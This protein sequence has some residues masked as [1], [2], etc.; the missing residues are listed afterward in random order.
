MKFEI[1][2]HI[3]VQFE[4]IEDDTDF[5]DDARFKKVKVWVA[6]E[7]KNLNNSNFSLDVLNKMGSKVAG[8]PI[9]GYVQKDKYGDIDFKG[10][11]TRLVIEGDD[12]KFDYV[13]VPFGCI[14]ETNNAQIEPKTV[15]GVEKNF[16]T[17]EGVLWNKF[18]DCI[19]IFERDGD[20]K[21]Q[22]MELLPDSIKGDFKSDGIYYFTEAVIDSLCILGENVN[23]AMKGGSLDT[24]FSVS[25]FK[26]QYGE[27]IKE[28]KE[29]FSINQSLESVDNTSKETGGDNMTKTKPVEPIVEP[30]VEPTVPVT[31]V[32]EAP[33]EPA[34]SDD[35]T[36][37]VEPVVP[38]VTFS[39]TGEQFKKELKSQ[40]CEVKVKTDWDYV[41]A[42]YC[43]VD[44]KEDKVFAMDCLE[45]Y[46][47]YSFNFT[48][49]GDAVV[50]D[51]ASKA[52]VKVEYLPFEGDD[53][54]TGIED[55][56]AMVMEV[57]EVF[58]K[59]TNDKATEDA[60]KESDEKEKESEAK[61]ATL[62]AEA[63]TL[64]EFQIGVQADERATQ[65]KGIFEKYSMLEGEVEFEAIKVDATKF[66]VIEL[67]KECA[68]VY[69]TKKANFTVA[70]V[71]KTA[72]IAVDFTAE[73]KVEPYGGLMKKFKGKK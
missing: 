16:L 12:I 33:V 7:G 48:T 64:R 9:V 13:G 22:S 51:F 5:E 57:V 42:Q 37:P 41:Y 8:I 19:D 56:I 71:K 36:T 10:H 3:P 54:N 26:Q 23:P 29:S 47:I 44:Y 31:P 52:R 6:H 58:N 62:E 69:V 40:L 59:N 72:K 38:A 11:E 46:A 70:P 27:M 55:A 68:L 1:D 49:N 14:L 35:G 30:I 21:S 2:T 4:I 73:A 32:F 45:C 60:K 53:E 17:C 34:V 50:I 66:S 65:E 15:D 39:L 67:E 63:V 20:T 61:F 18:T 43:Y 25:T 24:N 28:I